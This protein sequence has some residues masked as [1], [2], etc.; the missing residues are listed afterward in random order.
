MLH[1][2]QQI[3]WGFHIQQWSRATPPPPLLKGPVA[4][5]LVNDQGYR[6]SSCLSKGVALQGGCSSYTCD[7]HATLCNYDCN[8]SKR[9]MESGNAPG[10]SAPIQEP[11]PQYWWGLAPH[12]E[13]TTRPSICTGFSYR[14]TL[15]AI[16]SQ[17]SFVLVYPA[18]DNYSAIC[19]PE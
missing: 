1:I 15:V 7:C 18:S 17:S 14:A 11:Q 8:V 6:T 5:S 2:S 10:T 9:E 19:W 13:S 12:R 4:P 16:T 3:F